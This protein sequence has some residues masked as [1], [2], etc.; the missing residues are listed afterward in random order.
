MDNI[1]EERVKIANNRTSNMLTPQSGIDISHTNLQPV[2]FE[3]P[4][5][6]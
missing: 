4:A 5:P 3:I 2:I 1:P 6:N